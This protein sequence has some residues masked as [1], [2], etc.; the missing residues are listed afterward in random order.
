MLE[1]VS[2]IK[3][4]GK[5]VLHSGCPTYLGSHL[6][7]VLSFLKNVSRRLIATNFAKS[8]QN[9]LKALCCL[10]DFRYESIRMFRKLN[11]SYLKYVFV[12]AGNPILAVKIKYVVY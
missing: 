6:T 2:K 1:R 4:P 8:S 5:S 11:I 10:L 3:G 12:A 7:R 9:L